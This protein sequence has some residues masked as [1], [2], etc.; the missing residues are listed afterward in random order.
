[1]KRADC[2]DLETAIES[3]QAMDIAEL[4][5]HQIAGKISRFLAR[6]VAT[7]KLAMRN[8]KP[9]VS[10]TFD[11]AAASACSTGAE[12]L[13]SQQARGTYYISAAACGALSP[14]GR[15][16]TAD[17]I[18]ALHGS[19]NEIGCHTYSHVP[20]PNI[21]RD[22]LCSEISRN[23]LVLRDILGNDAARNFAYPYGYLSFAAKR[24]LTHQFNS[25]RSST[26]GI[27][28]RAADLGALRSVPLENASIDQTEIAKLLD[29]TVRRKGWLIF[30]SHDVSAEPSR[31]GVTP[32]LFLFAVRTARQ[33]GCDL[34]TV[35]AA[36]EILGAARD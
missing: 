3:R 21:D 1:M 7:K 18:K 35:A 15:L 22:A 13:E 25:C 36:L 23:R 30:A 31:F 34:V 8:R 9:L 32:E 2:N 27:N 12:L 20:V 17:Q 16:A 4:P 26:L 14:T 33:M 11:D 5:R 10:F 28:T 24:Y 6:N 29:E 19:G